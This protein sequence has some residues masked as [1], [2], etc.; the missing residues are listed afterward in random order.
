VCGVCAGLW[1]DDYRDFLSKCLQHNPN[2]RGTTTQL[3]RHPFL[4]QAKPDEPDILEDGPIEELEVIVG[5]IYEHLKT[6]RHEMNADH[7]G[8]V[9]ASV[10]KKY[11]VLSIH[12]MCHRILFGEPP[13]SSNNKSDHSN[14]P[15]GCERL[16]TLAHQLHLDLGLATQVAKDAL[17]DLRLR[18]EAALTYDCNAPTPKAVHYH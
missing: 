17:N 9:T 12:E 8:S 16:A 3:L 6:I 5:G 2:D 7:N 11:N 4:S 1:S 18:D 13:T 15:G 14:T 10:K